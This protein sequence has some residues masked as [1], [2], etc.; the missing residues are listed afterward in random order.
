MTFAEI[1]DARR[2]QLLVQCA[3]VISQNQN[4]FEIVFYSVGIH[5]IYT[6]RYYNRY[7]YKCYTKDNEWYIIRIYRYFRVYVYKLVMINNNVI[8]RA[9]I[10]INLYITEFHKNL[11]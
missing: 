11:S 4:F 1:R 2:S 9:F 6:L 8:Y 3:I 7:L 5:R 10:N